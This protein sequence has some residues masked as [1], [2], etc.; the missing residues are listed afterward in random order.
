MP[1]KVPAD[2]MGSTGWRAWDTVQQQ[3]QDREYLDR[4]KTAWAVPEESSLPAPENDTW[5]EIDTPSWLEV[6]AR[7]SMS[8]RDGRGRLPVR[9][10]DRWTGFVSEVFE[11]G[12]FEVELRT[13]AADGDTI[14]AEFRLDEVDDDDLDLVIQGAP[15]YV[16]S[17]LFRDGRRV[18]T[19]ASVRFR[20]LPPWS[21]EELTIAKERAR[22]RMQRL[23]LQFESP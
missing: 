20:R 15:V 22:K 21:E 16:T 8:T 23:G 6:L 1:A 4:I 3:F 12:F 7:L 9:V 17:G 10:T 14:L 5:D 11:D 2:T 13:A 18:R 19:V